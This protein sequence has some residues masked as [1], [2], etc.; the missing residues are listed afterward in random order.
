VLVIAVP[1]SAQERPPIAQQIAKAYGLDSFGQIEAIR[2]TFNAKGVLNLARTWIWEPKTNQVSY[3]G[4]DKAGKPQ[5]IF[6]SNVSVKLAGS[7][8]WLNTQ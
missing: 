5:R 8:T 4:R 3:E 2:Y 1:S 6:F 7:D